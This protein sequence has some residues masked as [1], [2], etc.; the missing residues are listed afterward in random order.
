MIK[1][2]QMEEVACRD[3]PFMET[4]TYYPTRGA[5]FRYV[6][7]FVLLFTIKY[8]KTHLSA[9]F[10]LHLSMTMTSSQIKN[11]LKMY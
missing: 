10:K 3:H 1:E 6:A 4:D 2:V 5:C 7:N 11:I 8:R 9:I